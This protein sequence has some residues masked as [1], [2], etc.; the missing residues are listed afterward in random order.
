MAVSSGKRA[1]RLAASEETTYSV[2]FKEVRPLNYIQESYLEAINNN[3][4]IF[5]VGSAGTGKTFIATSYAA[6]QLYHRKID[7]LILT[8]PNVETGKGLGFL[9]GNL[10][11]KYAPYLDPFDSVLTKN[12]GQGFYE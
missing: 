8:R 1:R 7:K 5:G 2:E 6:T 10:D 12:L 4:I 9:P 11:E 3:D